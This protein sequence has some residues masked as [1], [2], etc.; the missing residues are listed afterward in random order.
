MPREVKSLFVLCTDPRGH[1]NTLITFKVNIVVKGNA[2]ACVVCQVNDDSF[3]IVVQHPAPCLRDQ[4]IT[5]ETKTSR[6]VGC[7][8]VRSLPGVC[9]PV[10]YRWDTSLAVLS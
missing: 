10:R 3:V 1:V 8:P 7:V 6:I 5:L 4:R 2:T 9:A